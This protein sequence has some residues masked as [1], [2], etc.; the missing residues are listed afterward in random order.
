MRPD[1]LPNLLELLARHGIA[2]ALSDGRWIRRE[3]MLELAE[4]ATV[5]FLYVWWMGPDRDRG[6]ELHCVHGADA[7]RNRQNAPSRRRS[8]NQVSSCN[9]RAA[10]V[11]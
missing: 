11:R 5:D 7:R 4:R 2:L 6:H 9:A 8:P 3:T 1:V 10:A